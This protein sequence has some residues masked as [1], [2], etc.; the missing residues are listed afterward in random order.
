MEGSFA[1]PGG[2][3][4]V[5]QTEKNRVSEQQAEGLIRRKTRK[6]MTL[7]L[8]CITPQVWSDAGGFVGGLAGQ[9][10]WIIRIMAL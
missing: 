10:L 4:P 3:R 1:S 5:F 6:V 9:N 8:G 7:N 2:R